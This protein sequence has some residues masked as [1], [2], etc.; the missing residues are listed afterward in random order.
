MHGTCHTTKKGRQVLVP[1]SLELAGL[2]HLGPDPYHR[3]SQECDFPVT[4]P[5]AISCD[6]LALWVGRHTFQLH[7]QE[8]VQV[9]VWPCDRSRGPDPLQSSPE[10]HGIK[11]SDLWSNS[12][13]SVSLPKA[14]RVNHVFPAWG[15]VSML[16]K[17]FLVFTA[18][19]LS[20]FKFLPDLVEKYGLLTQN[21]CSAWKAGDPD[22]SPWPTTGS[23]GSF[24][25]RT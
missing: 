19:K 16:W 25:H 10:G 24:R 7:L 12:S 14:L 5:M 15:L 18:V 22:H 6:M 21:K 20:T 2:T 13:A 9:Q 4:T 23:L 1:T 3:W 8:Y 11:A 17:G